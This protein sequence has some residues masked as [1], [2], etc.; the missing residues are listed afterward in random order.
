VTEERKQWDKMLDKQA[1][2]L[3]TKDQ[4]HPQAVA[5]MISDLASPDAINQS[6]S[7]I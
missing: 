6:P 4:T 7:P 2:L 1:D 3:R 5:R